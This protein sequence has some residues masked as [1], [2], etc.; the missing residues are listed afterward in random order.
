MKDDP[1]EEILDDIQTKIEIPEFDTQYYKETSKSMDLILKQNGYSRIKIIPESD[2]LSN[3]YNSFDHLYYK[4]HNDSDKEPALISLIFLKIESCTGNIKLRYPKVDYEPDGKLG[5]NEKDTIS[6]DVV[7]FPIRIFKHLLTSM[8]QSDYKS[9][10]ITTEIFEDLF[11]KVFPRAEVLQHPLRVKNGANLME[12]D[13]HAIILLII[14]TYLSN[15]L[16]MNEFPIPKYPETLL[17]FLVQPLNLYLYP[18]NQM[19]YH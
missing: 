9:F 17:S 7:N 11:V 2:M 8:Q 16:Y 5:R 6:N 18:K 14:I 10:R 19:M 1:I 4:I 12:I 13:V 3:I 15:K